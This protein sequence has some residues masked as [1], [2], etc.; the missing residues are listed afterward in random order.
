MR[1]AGST[2]EFLGAPVGKWCATGCGL[3]WCHSESLS[4]AYVWGAPKGPEI[5]ELLR[6]FGALFTLPGPSD[7]ILDGRR[8]ER[9]EPDALEVALEWLNG[10]RSLLLRH[11]R[12][13]IGVIGEGLAAVTMM[14]LLPIVGD[15]HPFRV[16]R[17]A[18]EALREVAPAELADSLHDELERSVG[19]ALDVAPIVQK[20]RDAID[21]ASASTSIHDAARRMALSTR[22]LQRALGAAG[23]SFQAELRAVRFDAARRLLESTDQKIAA[24]ASAV[25]LS[26]G[27]LT[28]LFKERVSAT[29]A[30]YRKR[31]QSPDR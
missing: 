28:Q 8:V 17:D 31:F 25:G 19:V 9:V 22:T 20:L 5:A 12:L 4:G 2:T 18:R 6:L 1:Q 24:V 29:P 23:T 26:E 13:Q 14:G 10:N 27:A 15:T 3:A 7:V 21:V 30:E 16:V 11:V